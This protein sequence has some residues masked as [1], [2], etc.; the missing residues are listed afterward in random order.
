MNEK[1]TK[2]DNYIAEHPSAVVD[3]DEA[4]F[5]AEVSAPFEEIVADKLKESK[6]AFVENYDKPEIS[7]TES[8]ESIKRNIQISQAREAAMSAATSAAGY[9]ENINSK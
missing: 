9:Y 6:E 2:I 1:E 7:S 3:K 8:E 5:M 4:Q